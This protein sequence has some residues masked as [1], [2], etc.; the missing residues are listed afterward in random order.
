MFFILNIFVKILFFSVGGVSVLKKVQSYIKL[1]VPAGMA[2]PSPPIG[3]AL[4]QRGVNIMDFCKVFNEKT[5]SIEKGSPI[6]VLITVYVDRSFTFIL[7]TPPASF[8]LKKAAGI[9]SGSCTPNKHEVGVVTMSQVIEIAKI[10][11]NDM[12]GSDIHAMSRS[13]QGTAISMG[14]KVK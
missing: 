2:N 6:S 3:P 13:I 7:K 9:K 5:N 10:K 8:L 12:T 14:I 4:G 11:M 1:Q